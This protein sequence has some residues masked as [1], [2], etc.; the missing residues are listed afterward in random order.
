MN[1]VFFVVTVGRQIDG[2][3]QMVRFE[4]AFNKASKADAYAKNL[5]LNWQE[6]VQTPDGPVRFACQRG[7][8]ECDFDDN[9]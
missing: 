5:T 1:K 4:K 9:E 2:D 6:N 7:V 3:Q 8:H